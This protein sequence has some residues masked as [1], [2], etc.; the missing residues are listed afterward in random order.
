MFDSHVLTKSNKLDT[1]V[2]LRRTATKRVIWDRALVARRKTLYKLGVR[3]MACIGW[4]RTSFF[5]TVVSRR[6]VGV[7]LYSGTDLGIYERRDGPSTSL[8]LPLPPSPLEVGPLKLARGLRER[9][10]S[11][12]GTGAVPRTKTSLVH[13]KAFRKTMVAINLNILSTLFYGLKR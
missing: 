11:P 10:N 13:S 9:F 4:Q 8:P 2:M 3:Q 6:H 12:A 1:Y 7:M 5:H